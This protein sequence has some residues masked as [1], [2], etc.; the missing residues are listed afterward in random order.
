MPSV[1]DR[2]YFNSEN[3]TQGVAGTNRNGE[4]VPVQAA[5]TV[6]Y[7]NCLKLYGNG[8][9]E[10]P[11]LLSASPAAITFWMM[12]DLDTPDGYLMRQHNGT[13]GLTLKANGD[14][15]EFQVNQT[16][17]TVDRDGGNMYSGYGIRWQNGQTTLIRNGLHIA[18]IEEEPVFPA[19]AFYLGNGLSAEILELVLIDGEINNAE[20][21]GVLREPYSDLEIVG[22]T[23]PDPVSF[24]KAQT[25]VRED[26][27]TYLVD[28]KGYH[29][30][31]LYGTMPGLIS[32]DGESD[33]AFAW[34]FNN[35]GY[36]QAT[37]STKYQ[38][39]GD[40]TISFWVRPTDIG[41]RDNPLDKVYG[42]EFSFSQETNGGL[43]CYN[44]TTGGR[45]S[46]YLSIN[47]GT[48]TFSN[49]VWHHVTYTRDIEGG[50]TSVYIDGVYKSGRSDNYTSVAASNYVLKIGHG[51][52]ETG[53]R[54]AV[55][56]IKFWEQ[57]LTPDEV[58]LNFNEEIQQFI[59]PVGRFYNVKSNA[60]IRQNKEM[61]WPYWNFPRPLNMTYLE[62]DENGNDTR[63]FRLNRDW[64][65]KHHYHIKSSS[66]KNKGL[67]LDFKSYAARD[68]LWNPI[69]EATF[70][71]MI[72]FIQ[73][74][75]SD[76]YG[77]PQLT[78][79][80][81]YERRYGKWITEVWS[82]SAGVY[83]F[84]NLNIN[85]AYTVVAV[86]DNKHYNSVI[87]DYAMPEAY[88]E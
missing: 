18:T 39:T 5:S 37:D 43:S 52:I 59:P 60:S 26:G 81:L 65:P 66:Y 79:V 34:V 69:D 25:E 78:R 8:S 42:G 33:P 67:A 35:S 13:D 68:E 41:T 88:P 80:R 49:N 12:V 64:S 27:Y 72:G 6:D 61:G 20:L 30:L 84:D 21:W 74:T 82:N 45:S 56:Q 40:L 83:R 17:V 19:V 48:N 10:V 71:T 9:F 76:E 4:F 22:G 28:E 51:Y 50:I 85:V 14:V 86:D 15:I 38:F 46:P 70:K 58:I 11:Y 73:G 75:I 54:G 32:D 77:S 29:D 62:D 23:V 44:G 47:P 87:A 36:W 57:T 63:E 1:L 31:Q 53:Y 24:F 2:F 55:G 7:G 16:V 3:S